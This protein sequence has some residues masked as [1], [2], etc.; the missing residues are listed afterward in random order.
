MK[1]KKETLSRHK[2][3]YSPYVHTETV[4]VG[5]GAKQSMRDEC[6]VNNIVAKYES[7]GVLTHLNATQA[8]WADVS[9]V[10]G[11]R[12]A[13][14][15]VDAVKEAFYQLPSELRA[16]F[17]N[18]PAQYLD[19]MGTVTD[20]QLKELGSKEYGNKSGSVTPDKEPEKAP[21]T[22]DSGESG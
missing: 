11:Y 16:Q 8:S 1:K 2:G 18:D 22:A 6:D 14:E 19:F 15:K 17:E 20:E 12:E 9:E 13:L 4:V 3:P 7:T 21:V 5:P 10:G